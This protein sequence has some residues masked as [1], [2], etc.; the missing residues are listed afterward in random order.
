MAANSTMTN[1]VDTEHASK[2][3]F[4]DQ[5]YDQLQFMPSLAHSCEDTSSSTKAS[6][7]AEKTFFSF[8]DLT[9]T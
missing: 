9:A 1:V 5:K 6:L 2:F 7:K 4:D 3:E 8:W